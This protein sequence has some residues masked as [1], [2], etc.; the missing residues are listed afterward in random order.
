MLV[1]GGGRVEDD[2]LL[3]RT[4][5]ALKQGARG[6]VYGRNVIQHPRPAALVAALLGIL[7]DGLSTERASERLRATAGSPS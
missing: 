5:A 4:E 1:R 2:E 3:R 7:H 6:I